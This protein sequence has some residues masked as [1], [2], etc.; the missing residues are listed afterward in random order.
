M[1][2]RAMGMLGSDEGYVIAQKGAGS[3][4]AN[5]R[6]LAALALGA[7]ARSDTQDILRKLL[8]DGD[9]NVRIAAATAILLV[10]LPSAESKQTGGRCSC[11]AAFGASA[12]LERRPPDAPKM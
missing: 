11:N 7:I 8:A 12:S 4:D 10:K 2:A 3:S 6:V 5:Q 1:A 9:A